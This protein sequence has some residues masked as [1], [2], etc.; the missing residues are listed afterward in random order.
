MV[1]LIEAGADEKKVPSEPFRPRDSGP[2]LAAAGD[3]LEFARNQTS[4]GPEFFAAAKAAIMRRAIA[5]STS[6]ADSEAIAPTARRRRSP[7]V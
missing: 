2:V 3:F 6:R 1:A 5:A 4:Q 7:S